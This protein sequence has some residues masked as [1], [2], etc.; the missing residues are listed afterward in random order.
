MFDAMDSDGLVL[1]VELEKAILGRRCAIAER[2]K[3]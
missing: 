2:G 1:V 3:K